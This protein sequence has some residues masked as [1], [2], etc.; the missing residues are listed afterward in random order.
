MDKRLPLGNSGVMAIRSENDPGGAEDPLVAASAHHRSGRLAEA[1]AL[2]DEILRRQPGHPEALNLLGVLHA[3]RRQ[4]DRARELL[5]AAIAARPDDPR[6][7]A[8][9]ART[10][11]AAGRHAEAIDA[12]ERALR[13][14]PA[15]AVA[16]IDLGNLLVGADR[17]AEAADCFRRAIEVAPASAAAHEGLGFAL[18]RQH[19]EDDALAAFERAVALDPESP[20]AH[21]NLGGLHLSKGRPEAAVPCFR[22]AVALVPQSAELHTNLGVALQSG[23]ALDDALAAYDAALGLDPSNARALGAKGIVLARLGRASQAAEIFDYDRLLWSKHVAAAPGYP[24]VA[25]FNTALVD[26]VCRHPSLMADRPGRTTRRGKQTGNLLSE[27]G[28]PIPSLE[29]MI[30]EAVEDYFAEAETAG[31]PYCPRRPRSWRLVAWATV[32]D[33]GGHQAPHNHP[34]GVLSGV[35]YA[36]LP[37]VVRAGDDPEAGCLEFGRPN[38]DL[39]GGDLS[40]VRIVRPAEGLVVLFPSHF[41]HRTI[42]YESD[43]KRISIAFDVT[44]ET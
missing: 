15:N 32:L 40:R 6:Y 12:Y 26:F 18:L 21:A 33:S 42:E 23:G 39:G 4:F 28:G 22:R 27:P 7:Q 19:R 31:H 20:G 17:V 24:S 10:L 14:D 34:S 29:A 35:Y 9:L 3:Q 37:S 43:E 5:A 30:R 16:R 38:Q 36:Q 25:A 1:E 11:R 41:W 8:N 44:P 13:L 2:Y